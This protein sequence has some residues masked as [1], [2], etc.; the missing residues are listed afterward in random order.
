MEDGARITA[1]GRH[2][3]LG[4]L[5]GLCLAFPL[6]AG[7]SPDG[8]ASKDEQFLNMAACAQKAEVALGQMAMERAE[9]EKVKQ[10]AQRMVDDHTKAGQEV[11]K[12]AEALGIALSNE[13]AIEQQKT[14]DTL[15]KLGGQ[16]FDRAYVAHEVKDHQK[17]IAAF[18]KQSRTL[19]QSPVKQWA[20]GAIPVLKEHLIIAK[21]VSRPPKKG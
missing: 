6:I 9:S 12:L 13:P 7:A 17:T 1:M 10:F 18:K 19:K 21:S 11:H 2:S 4:G 5:L 20:A 15:S 14:Q 16:E 3:F 8:P